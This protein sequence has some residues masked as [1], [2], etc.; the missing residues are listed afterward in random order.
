SEFVRIDYAG[1]AKLYVPVSQLHLIGRYT[2][3][4]AEHAPLH[5]LGR[6]EWE[7]AKKKAAAK[8]RDT[9]AELLHLY[10]LRESR[11][12]FAFAEKIPEYQA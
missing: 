3:T 6:G 10:A 2:G 5:S 1:E 9:A 8:V 11:Q 4:D 12:G 7:R